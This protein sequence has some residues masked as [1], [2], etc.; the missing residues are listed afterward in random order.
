KKAI[1]Y[2]SLYLIG[3]NIQKLIKSVVFCCIFCVAIYISLLS[4]RLIEI[5][6][7]LA[8]FKRRNDLRNVFHSNTNYFNTFQFHHYLLHSG[9][10]YVFHYVLHYLLHYYHLHLFQLQLRQCCYVDYPQQLLGW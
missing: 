4:E 7:V 3:G 1:R 8:F 6:N 9:Q 5:F 2:D 10:P